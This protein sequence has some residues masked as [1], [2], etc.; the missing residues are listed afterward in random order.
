M[1][2]EQGQVEQ[3]LGHEVA[4]AHGVERVLEAAG[5]AEVGGDAV[6]VERQR[7]AG[8]GAGAE[9]RHV[10]PADGCRAAGRRRGPAPSRG[11]AGGGPAAPAGPAAGGCSRAGRRRPAASARSSRTSWRARTRPATA[12]QRALGE[13][14]QVGGHLVV[15]AAAGVQLGPGV[16]GQLGDPPLDGGVD[17]LVAGLEGEG[18]RRPA[19]RSTRSRAASR[20]V[21]LVR[22][23][24]ARPRTRPRTWAREPGEVVGG[25]PLV[26]RQADGEGQQLLGRAVRRSGRAR[27]S[28]AARVADRRARGPRRAWRAAQVSTPRPHSR[29]KPS[30]SSWRKRSAAS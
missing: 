26:E 1:D 24:G 21:G 30:A 20:I 9:R 22:R 15:A 13:Q 7:R 29:T 10:E 18:A 28:S 4:V 17:V 11:P 14:A 2:A 19:P 8:Q 5:E 27:A 25:Q 16:A 12:A 3:G 6:G 23:R